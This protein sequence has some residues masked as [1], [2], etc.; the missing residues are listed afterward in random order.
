MSQVRLRDKAAED[1]YFRLLRRWQDAGANIDR[2]DEPTLKFLW[3]QLERSWR[4]V[5]YIFGDRE[6][7]LLNPSGVGHKDNVPTEFI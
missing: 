3:A 6:K 4:S 2:Y 5:G 1:V 7:E